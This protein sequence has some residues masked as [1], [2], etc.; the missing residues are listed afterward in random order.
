M[1]IKK[2]DL[3]KLDNNEM[4]TF[5][6]F[7][8]LRFHKEYLSNNTSKFKTT[9]KKSHEWFTNNNFK[10][11]I[12]SI[13][14]K[15]RKKTFIGGIIYDRENFFYSI[16]IQKKYRKKGHAEVALKKLI[17]VVKRKKLK[18]FTYLKKKNLPSINLHK[19][20]IKYK[21]KYNKDFYWVRL[22]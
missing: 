22:V 9:K 3:S 12:F 14:L 1:E 19:K 8:R 10:K 13:N 15:D 21:K 18:L 5:N 4:E 20:Y 7:Y 2:I 17:N 6:I 11:W 16:L